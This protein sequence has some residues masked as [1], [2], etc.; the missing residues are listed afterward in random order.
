MGGRFCIW[1]EGAM[2]K[3]DEL[4]VTWNKSST[5]ISNFNLPSPLMANSDLTKLL[6]S[7]EIQGALRPK[8]LG[9]AH[10]TVKRNPLK[11]ASEMAKLNP[12]AIAQKRAMLLKEQ[13][14]VEAKSSKISIVDGSKSMKRARNHA[15]REAEAKQIKTKETQRKLKEAL[16]VKDLNL[17]KRKEEA[18]A[19][20]AKDSEVQPLKSAADAAK[21]VD[22]KRKEEEAVVVAEQKRKEEEAVRPAELK[23]KEEE[24]AR[25]AELKHK[26]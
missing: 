15:S 17:K 20:A 5:M 8:K 14:N 23:R 7:Q 21:V 10:V 16:K 12:F 9:C 4:F 25:L 22:F 6:S 19:K 13:K 24:A 26:E 3:L 18:V 1:T 2:R 11:N